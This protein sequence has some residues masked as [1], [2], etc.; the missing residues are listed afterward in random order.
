MG[1]QWVRFSVYAGWIKRYFGVSTPKSEQ[2]ARER[3]E[4]RQVKGVLYAKVSE[5]RCRIYRRAKKK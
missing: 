5:E 2:M 1:Y 4:I 3:A